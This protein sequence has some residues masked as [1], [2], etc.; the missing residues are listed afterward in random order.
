M[1]NKKQIYLN[2]FYALS[3]TMALALLFFANAETI[4]D[5][6]DYHINIGIGKSFYI[7]C[8]IAFITSFFL[9]RHPKDRFDTYLNIFTILTIVSAI[10][11]PKEDMPILNQPITRFLGGVLCFR[12]IR[13][14]PIKILIQYI[15]YISPII[16][17]LHFILVN[18]FEIY[19]FSGFYG[20]PNYLAIAFNLIITSC[21]LYITR[22]G[23]PIIN[24]GAIIS[25]L[26]ALL[27]IL[28]GISRGGILATCVNLIYILYDLSLRNKKAS[29][30]IICLAIAS[31]GSLAMLFSEQIDNVVSRFSGERDSDVGAAQ[32][33]GHEIISGI[34]ILR[35]HPEMTFFGI[36]IGNSAKAH[37]TYR[38]A[39][40]YSSV[41]IHNTPISILVEQ[42]ILS[43]LCFISVFLVRIKIL[44]LKKSYASLGLL[45]GTVI[46]LNTVA[47]LAFMPFWIILFYIAND[48]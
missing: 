32:S 5:I 16:I 17:L 45:L 31:S 48:K 43:L 23:N 26:G 15:T 4:G 10:I 2:R 46:A 25:I 47:T 37:T 22:Y 6:E 33:R 21:Y 42:G 11:M 44:L 14:I 8:G 9:E 19:R 1:T 29:I 30:L 36:G 20:D 38:Y 7:P 41:R 24:C 34:N 13:D 27:L 35:C 40:Y 28:L 39:G 12:G 3:V 18:P